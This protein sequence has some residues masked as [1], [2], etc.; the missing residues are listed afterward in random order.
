[1]VK[2]NVMSNINV[3]DIRWYEDR[4]KEV[5]EALL[6]LQRAVRKFIAYRKQQ[7]TALIVF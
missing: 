7:G 6:R 3:S 4:A 1:M 2:S 5:P